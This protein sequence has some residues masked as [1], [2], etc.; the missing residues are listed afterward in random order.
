MFEFD[1]NKSASNLEKH[2]ID[3]ITAQQLWQDD[4]RLAVPAKTQGRHALPSLPN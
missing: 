2:G 4:Y 1:P 3:F